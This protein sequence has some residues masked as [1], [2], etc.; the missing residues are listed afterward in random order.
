MAYKRKS[1]LDEAIQNRQMRLHQVQQT[2]HRLT[3]GMTMENMDSSI[4]QKSIF[5]IQ[6]KDRVKAIIKRVLFALKIQIFTD[7]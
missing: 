2:K 6:Q 5:S 7:F 1:N 4:V 3:F